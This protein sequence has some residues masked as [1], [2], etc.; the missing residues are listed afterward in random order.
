MVKKII[1]AAI[2]AVGI[3]PAAS[4]QFN[5]SKAINSASKATQALT[6][7]DDQVAAYARE[8]VNWMDTHNKV[9][10]PDSEYTQR[11]NR[12]TEGLTSAD[13]I[14]LNFKVYEVIDINAFACPDGSVRVFSSLMD[15]MD[16][17]EL[18]GVI[19]HNVHQR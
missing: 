17:D 15:I 3:I 7:S 11:L 18:L 16:D 1:L 12:L 13:G 2:M 5:L 6:L 10:D 9:S 4:A 14:P 19:G 8:S